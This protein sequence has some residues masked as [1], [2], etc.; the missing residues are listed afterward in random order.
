MVT[1]V[2]PP[3][4]GFR[5]AAS[6]QLR[7]F[8]GAGHTMKRRE[9]TPD[10]ST[11]ASVWDDV[12]ASIRRTTDFL[13]AALRPASLRQ[14][15]AVDAPPMFYSNDAFLEG[16]LDEHGSFQYLF[17]LACVALEKDL[18]PIEFTRADARPQ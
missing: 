8:T 18:W 10:G 12:I 17:K 14:K 3:S 1:R 2:P 5:T 13:P 6:K 15:L 16:P 7:Q 11:E 9:A 4:F